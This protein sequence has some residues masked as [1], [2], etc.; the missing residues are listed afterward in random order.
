[1]AG[2]PNPGLDRMVL[3]ALRNDIPVVVAAGNDGSAA[4]SHSPGRVRAVLSVGAIKS[5]YTLWS[6]SPVLGLDLLAPGIDITSTW[7]SSSVASVTLSGTSMS[8]GL[9]SGLVAYHLSLY[10]L[11]PVKRINRRL[12]RRSN[13]L[14][15]AQDVGLLFNCWNVDC[16]PSRNTTRATATAAPS[17]ITST[18]DL[19]STLVST[20]VT[21]AEATPTPE[22]A[23]PPAE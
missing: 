15:K 7:I 10:P 22:P 17:T 4:T 13:R 1:M 19:T 8:A 16:Y 18:V 14:V 20:E 23:A 6:G 5:D 9:V 12:K 11:L 21:S 2:P 3:H